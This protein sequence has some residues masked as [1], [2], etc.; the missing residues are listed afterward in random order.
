MSD[1]PFTTP[2]EFLVRTPLYAETAYSDEQVWD[3][4]DLL[5]F[6]G[7]YDSFCIGCAKES[8]FR[9]VAPKRPQDLVSN[10][11]VNEAIKAQGGTPALP[12]VSARSYIVEAKCTRVSDH[13]QTF[14]VLIDRRFVKD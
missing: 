3:V 7:T 5:Y 2:G 12:H 13:M 14:F 9:G 1:T 10:R 6:E 4:L 8:T 11:I